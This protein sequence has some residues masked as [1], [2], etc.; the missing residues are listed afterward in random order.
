MDGK[1]PKSK[2]IRSLNKLSFLNWLLPLLSKTGLKRVK[3]VNA[4][5]QSP[6]TI[7]RSEFETKEIYKWKNDK[8]VE[9]SAIFPDEAFNKEL[10]MFMEANKK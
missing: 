9:V 6:F 5:Y 4:K 10:A 2:L 8:I 3:S 7:Y 1:I